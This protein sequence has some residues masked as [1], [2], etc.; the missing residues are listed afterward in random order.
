VGWE[1]FLDSIR[2]SRLRPQI[3]TATVMRSVVVMLL[4][5]L[6]SLH[7][8]EQSRPSRFWLRWLGREMPS[9]D[10]VGRVCALAEAETLR[11]LHHQVY[12][13]LKRMKALEPP[14]HG[15]IPAILDG[16]E[17]H[18][19]FRRHCSGCL[20]RV[21]H[22]SQ[23]DRI[24][25][26]HRYVTLQLVGR[27]LCILLD[28]EPQQAGEDEVAAAL[29]LLE[30]VLMAYPRA[31]D[32]IV[33]DALYADSR[34]FNWAL[35]HG[36]EAMAVLK[37]DRRDLFQDA[38]GLFE[39]LAPAT[40]WHQDRDCQC[41]DSEGFTSWPQV[42]RPVRVVRSLEKWSVRR[43]LD[44][45]IEELSS[46]WMWVTTLSKARATTKA[47]LQMGHSR[48]NIENQGFNE[49]V[50][51]WH[52]DHVYKHEPQAMLIFCLMAMVCLN[53]FMA[54]YQRNL[55]P[56]LRKAATMLCIARQVAAELL[57]DMRTDPARAPP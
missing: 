54:F 38:Q 51:Q 31:F 57:G 26:Y 45:Q 4:S 18:A 27:D 56:A 40:L 20:Q 50:N 9:A 11:A 55:K 5:R 8:L 39:Q 44:G 41:W 35:A 2:D 28:A 10:T 13:R 7:A 22:T 3:S 24:Q 33:A 30:R 12:S 17:S 48:W 47:I 16:H 37:D 42:V 15:L 23:A 46:A 49:L 34:V 32:V 14:A 52:A 53:V 36:K 25:Y 29:R 1:G 43:Q 6:G 19:T 21:I